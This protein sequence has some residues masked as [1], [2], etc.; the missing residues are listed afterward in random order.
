MAIF[1]HKTCAL[2]TYTEVAVM[3]YSGGFAMNAHENCAH[4]PIIPPRS[5]RFVFPPHAMVRQTNK[6]GERRRCLVQR[7][8]HGRPVSL[9]LHSVPGHHR[10]QLHGSVRSGCPVFRGLLLQARRG[11]PVS[12]LRSRRGTLRLRGVSRRPLLSDG[13]LRPNYMSTG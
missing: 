5:P 9:L 12:V 1:L 7:H 3:Y 8:R 2:L 6:Q 10:L 4:T 11:E 13:H